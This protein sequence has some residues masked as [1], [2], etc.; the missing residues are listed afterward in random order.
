M[1]CDMT[2]YGHNWK[3]FSAGI[4]L[5]RARGRCECH[6][7]C[8]LHRPSPNPNRCV[9]K[10]GSKALYAKGTVHLTTAHLCTCDPPCQNPEHVKA[11]CQ[12]C[13]LRFDSRR[14]AAARLAR[15]RARQ[16]TFQGILDDLGAQTTL[17]L[18]KE[19]P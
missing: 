18:A 1:P 10:N 15:L 16:R 4:K 7:E 6:G 9:E 12:R 14:H 17:R 13:H 3:N 19:G 2:R 8:G 5:G 11:M